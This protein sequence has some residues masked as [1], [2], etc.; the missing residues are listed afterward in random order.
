M[1]LGLEGV[2]PQH[3]RVVLLVGDVDVHLERRHPHDALRRVH[4]R[5]HEEQIVIGGVGHQAP[6]HAG[7]EFAGDEAHAGQHP[8]RPL[9]AQGVDE[10]PAQGPHG[11]RV[12]HEH[13]VFLEGDAP[14][15][16]LHAQGEGIST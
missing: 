6:G 3:L 10:F 14:L 12:Q 13:A 4:H 15:L 8:P 7:I 2:L 1:D 5:P 9:H 16:E 11:T